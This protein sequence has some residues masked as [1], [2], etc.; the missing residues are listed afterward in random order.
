MLAIP[1]LRETEITSLQG[2]KPTNEPISCVGVGDF[3]DSRGKWIEAMRASG[4]DV[5]RSVS[6]GVLPSAENPD[7][8]I[9]NGIEL[10]RDRIDRGVHP[11]RRSAMGLMVVAL[12]DGRLVGEL[13]HGGLLAGVG[14]RVE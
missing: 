5:Q 3:S 14:G 8:V 2:G 12:G 9:D 1:K 13:Q 6:I 4:N 11:V 10:A 7:A